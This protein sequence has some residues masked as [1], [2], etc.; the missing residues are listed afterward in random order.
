MIDLEAHFGMYQ[1]SILC[2]RLVSLVPS[3]GEK[4]FATPCGVYIDVLQEERVALLKQQQDNYRAIGGRLELHLTVIDAA[5][6]VV[7]SALD[8]KMDWYVTV[9]GI[10]PLSFACVNNCVCIIVP[11]AV[12][13]YVIT[14]SP[15]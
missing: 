3:S 5:T 15:L 14:A 13:L 10:L 12:I 4:T 1:H 6:A 11:G 7:R 2:Y 8:S 9:P